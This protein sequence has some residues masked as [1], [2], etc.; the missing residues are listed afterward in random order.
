MP[1]SGESIGMMAKGNGQ[2][3]LMTQPQSIMKL[4]VVEGTMEFNKHPGPEVFTVRSKPDLPR[5]E[6]FRKLQNEYARQQVKLNPDNAMI[7]LKYGL[8]GA[9]GDDGTNEP[10][11]GAAPDRVRFRSWIAWAMGALVLVSCAGV[12]IWKRRG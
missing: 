5:T 4:R 10:Q 7:L 9:S 6:S 1:V 3:I 8:Q 12:W 11:V 2:P